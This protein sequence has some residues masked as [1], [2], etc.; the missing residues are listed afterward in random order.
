MGVRLDYVQEK[1]PMGTLNAIRLGMR[2]AKEDVIV[3]NGDIICDINLK[4]MCNKW[5]KSR[6]WGSMFIVRMRSPYGI[7]RIKGRK[8]TGFQEKPLLDYYING[9]FY[10]LSQR[11]LPI[12]ERYKTGD[13]EKTAF[14]EM[15]KKGN[16][17]YYREEGIYWASIDS[18]KDLE[19][20]REEYSNRKDKPWG[21]EKLL[22]LDRKRMEKLLY[23]MA[24]YRTSMHYH[25]KRDEILKVVQGSGEVVYEDGK[26]K[27][28]KTGVKIHIK[29]G[30]V[31]SFVAKT[32]L[33][34]HERSTPH[35]NDAVRVKD[36]YDFRV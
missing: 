23:I 20:V 26:R 10:C 24:G 22:K 19:A 2:K 1:K 4:R 14:P 13:I 30:E 21:Y 35:P 18:P 33:L 25:R 15:A 34:L 9:G 8:I 27:L 7:V 31:H 17:T 11:V 6:T 12:L 32:N 36:F 29:P 5:R 28:L 3:S 16:L